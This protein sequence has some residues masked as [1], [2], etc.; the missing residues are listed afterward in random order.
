[1]ANALTKCFTGVGPNLKSSWR[2]LPWL[3]A[4]GLCEVVEA[5]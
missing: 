5:H 1:M 2:G 4:Q 3:A